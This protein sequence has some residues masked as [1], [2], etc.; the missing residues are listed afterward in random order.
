MRLVQVQASSMFP[1]SGD[2][3]VMLVYLVLVYQ[4]TFSPSPSS[5]EEEYTFVLL[6]HVSLGPFCREVR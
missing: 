1:S 2:I 5:G 6:T 4:L 3:F